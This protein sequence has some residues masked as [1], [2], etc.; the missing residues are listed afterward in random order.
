MTEIGEL[1]E[2][3]EDYLEIIFYLID[4]KKNVN[5]QDI[6][7]ENGLAA[8][9]VDAILQTLQQHGFI[10]ENAQEIKLT[11]KGEDLARRLVLRHEFL[12]RYLTEMLYVSPTVAEKDA[13]AIMH[14]LS[15]ETI[16]RMVAFFEYL[17]V[18]PNAGPELIKNF[19]NCCIL[20]RDN[21]ELSCTNSESC[22]LASRLK[23]ARSLID[24]KPGEKGRI[25]RVTARGAIRRRL[26]DMGVLPD[27]E[28]E[29]Q[30]VAPLGGAIKIK[31][32]GYHLTL[33]KTEAE[34]ILLKDNQEKC[35]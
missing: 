13:H 32:K 7:A 33:R 23:K 29:M 26:I 16:D 9:E 12:A 15:L 10:Q 22:P 3:Q 2:K 20:K 27:V 18:C 31:M 1:P 17:R 35:A 21:E 19:G 4:Q 14:H 25:L 30:S 28:V 6:I 8:P 5:K 24:L 11:L 34:G